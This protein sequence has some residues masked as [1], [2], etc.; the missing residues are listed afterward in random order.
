MTGN[1]LLTAL[2]VLSHGTIAI[3]SRGS[4][5]PTLEPVKQPWEVKTGITYKNLTIYPVVLSPGYEAPVSSAGY[6]TLDEGLKAG[7]IEVS[8]MGAEG[9]PLIRNGK[10]QA[11]QRNSGATVDTLSILNKSGRK[12]MMMSGEMVVGGKQDRIVQKD[13]LVMPGKLPVT[14]SVFCVEHNRWQGSDAKFTNYKGTTGATGATGATGS[15]GSGGAL[16]DISVRGAAQGGG[17]QG[18][19]WAEVANKNAKVSAAPATGT[20]Q[21]TLASPKAQTNS[22]EYSKAIL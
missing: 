12:L 13:A 3:T 18:R 10:A 8:E 22:Q 21:A 7:T 19:V 11:Q 14:M 20:Y 5:N 6:I 17:G 1:T 15:T 2:A 16:A 4:A 9:T